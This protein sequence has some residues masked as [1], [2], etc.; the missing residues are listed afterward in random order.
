MA[1]AGDDVAIGLEPQLRSGAGGLDGVGGPFRAVLV[2]DDLEVARL[3][4]DVIPADAILESLFLLLAQ[5]FAIE[6]EFGFIAGCKR[7]GVTIRSASS[8]EAEVGH[9]EVRP[10][11]GLVDGKRSGNRKVADAEI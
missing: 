3:I 5:R 6:E 11:L 8:S 7:D 10:P 9:R 4:D 2:G 1:V